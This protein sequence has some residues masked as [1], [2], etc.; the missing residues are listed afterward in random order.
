MNRLAVKRALDRFFLEDGFNGDITT[1]AIF[2]PS[3]KCV[4]HVKA[5]ARGIVSGLSLLEI[6]YSLLDDHIHVEERVKDG[7]E[8]RPGDV[9][10]T[11]QGPVHHVLFGERVLLNLIQRMSGIATVTRKAIDTLNDPSIRICDTRKT[12]PGLKLFEKYAVRSGGGYNH[13]LNL[14][15]MVLIKDNHIAQAKGIRQAVTQARSVIGHSL[16]IEV[17]VENREQL[18][19]A[20]DAGVDII[21]FDNMPPHI[22]KEYVA[23]V[24]DGIVTEASGGIS[25]QTIASYRGCGVDYLSLGFITHSAPI[26]DFT[27]LID[28]EGEQ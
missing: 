17:E 12:T 1:I 16:K 19:E 21:M 20:V 6:G 15:D 7:Q 10:A 27:L 3:E 28:E 23:L 11:I 13:R 26:L 24:P 5:K 2:P 22:I 25:L 14:S 9:I 18:E 8:V 4:A